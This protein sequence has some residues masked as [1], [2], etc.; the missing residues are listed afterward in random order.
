MTVIEAKIIL[1]ITE[2]SLIS[3]ELK[4]IF[5]RQ[6]LQWHPDI[7][8][9]RGISHLEATS[10]SQQIILAYEILSENLESLEDNSFKHTYESYYQYKT[11]TKK[12]L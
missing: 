2:G 1:G 7:S 11:S 8:I 3:I 10:K 5:K 4:K 9:N 12:K 6:M